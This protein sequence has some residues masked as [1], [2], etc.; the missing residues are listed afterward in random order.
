MPHC[1]SCEPSHCS[2]H[3][4]LSQLS[5]IRSIIYNT[6]TFSYHEGSPY[7][8]SP[9]NKGL[10]TSHRSPPL[11]LQ[12]TSLFHHA[13]SHRYQR[14]LSFQKHPSQ[15]RYLSSCSHSTTKCILRKPQSCN[16]PSASSASKCTLR[17]PIA[18]ISQIEIQA[19]GRCSHAEQQ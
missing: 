7:Q 18:R 13:G 16:Y 2:V 8:P 9:C 1:E 10:C 6:C 12:S 14:T 15:F 5:T 11:S 4:V 19:P 17:A 3:C